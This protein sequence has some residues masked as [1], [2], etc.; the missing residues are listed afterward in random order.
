MFA[1]GKWPCAAVLTVV[2]PA[3]AAGTVALAAGATSKPAAPIKLEW[4]MPKSGLQLSLSVV[5]TVAVGGRV[6]I[7]PAVR[8]AGVGAVALPSAAKAFGWLFVIQDAP[9]G[10]RAWYTQK[11]PLAEGVKG[12][13]AKLPGGRTLQLAGD[14]LA[15]RTVHQYRRGLKVAKGYPTDMS[16]PSGSKPAGQRLGDVLSSCKTRLRLMLYLPREAGS[17]MLVSNTLTIEVGAS[18]FG[19]L[20]PA[21]RKVLV[22]RLLKQFDKDAWAAM[23][24]HGEAVKIGRPVVGDLVGAARERKRPSFA[25][26]WLVTALCDIR[27]DESAAALVGLLADPMGGLH[28]VIGYHGPKQRSAT[29]DKAIIAK[30]GRG[31][32][33]SMTAYTLLGYMVF[34][35]RVPEELLAVSFDSTDPRVRATFAAALKSKASDLNITRLAALLSDKEERVRAAAAKALGAMKRP[36]GN[37]IE[38][39]VKALELPGD[40]ARK[41]V[42]DA[43]G[44][45]TG[46]KMP[47]DPNADTKTKQATLRAWKEWWAKAKKRRPAN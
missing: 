41:S 36:V 35:D 38:A 37:T 8:N 9:D 47:Y 45:L 39:L 16:A 25:R 2:L 12:W 21:A 42:A 40:Y 28:S 1:F 11:L 10:R 13:P 31:K 26:M 30:A 32:D 15:G 6:E 5:G 3:G 29:L 17:L 27:C 22:E 24:A 14:D 4:G 33:A 19:S 18:A 20:S 46:K 7:R 43:L 23:R 34:R 44:E